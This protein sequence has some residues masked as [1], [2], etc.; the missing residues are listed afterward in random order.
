MKH[1]IATISK[2]VSH[3]LLTHFERVTVVR[4]DDIK[5]CFAI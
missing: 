3:T 1:D 2:N 4:N 5:A